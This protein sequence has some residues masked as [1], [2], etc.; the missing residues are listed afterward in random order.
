MECVTIAVDNDPGGDGQKAA[1][2]CVKRLTQGG[3]EVITVQPTL[4]KDFNNVILER[5]HG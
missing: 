3:I 2:E 5:K 4:A 1:A